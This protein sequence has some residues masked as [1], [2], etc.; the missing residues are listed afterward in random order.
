MLKASSVTFIL[1]LLF[2]PLA[3]GSVESWAFFMLTLMTGTAF[4]FYLIHCLR[5]DHPFY[6]I[7]CFS[8]LLLL[9]SLL[10]FQ[11]I[12]LP[13]TVLNILSPQSLLF[14]QNTVGLFSGTTAWPVRWMSSLGFM[15]WP[16]SWFAA[17][18]IFW[19]SS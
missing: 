9:A 18:V 19:P 13:E 1:L 11:L 17:A 7:P 10:L 4:L 2:A 6:R 5:M 15:N 16:V 3:F 8:P 12:P 14:R